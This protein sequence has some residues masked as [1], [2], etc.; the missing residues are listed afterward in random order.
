MDK[1]TT[2]IT[3]SEVC[4]KLTQ[5]EL[6]QYKYEVLAFMQ[7]SIDPDKP[8]QFDVDVRVEEEEE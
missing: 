8:I 1:I 6:Q 4:D 5:E 7:M 3:I 2:V